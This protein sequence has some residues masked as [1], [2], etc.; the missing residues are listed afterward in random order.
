M[1]EY[2]QP[3]SRYE[4]APDLPEGNGH[5]IDR[6]QHKPDVHRVETVV[7]E[8]NRLPDPIDDIDRNAV[9]SSKSGS[10]PPHR[11]LRLHGGDRRHRRRQKHQVGS[12]AET[13][14]QQPARRIAHRL[15]AIPAIEQPVEDR[16]AESIYVR[17]QR[18]TACHRIPKS[19][20]NGGYS[21]RIRETY[22]AT[23]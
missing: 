8:R 11:R 10:H 6:A 14:E 19:I 2:D 21:S 7:Q 4:H 13:D 5:I 23:R 18:I 12:R 9:A 22:T 3:A 17:E 20:R 16:H 1:L 15:S